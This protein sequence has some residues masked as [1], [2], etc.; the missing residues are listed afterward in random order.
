[1]AVT[2]IQN[3]TTHKEKKVI[4]KISTIATLADEQQLSSPA[5]III[6]EVVNHQVKLTDYSLEQF[7]EDDFIQQNLGLL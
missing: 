3:G 6:G 4:G 5:I 1:L 7:I 2:I